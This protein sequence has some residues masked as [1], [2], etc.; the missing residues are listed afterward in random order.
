[1]PAQQ[2]PDGKYAGTGDFP[3]W[4]MKYFTFQFKN[5]QYERT[6]YY[7][8]KN[9]FEALEAND[10]SLTVLDVENRAMDDD[11]M[12][13]LMQSLKENTV[14]TELKLGRNLS[15]HNEQGDRFG[16]ALAPILAKSKIITKVDLHNNDMHEKAIAAIAEALKYNKSITELNLQDNFARKQAKD[17][18]DALKVNTTLTSLNMNVNQKASESTLRAGDGRQSDAAQ[19][20]NHAG[21]P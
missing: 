5:K 3:E 2:T 10:P 11:Q 19:L 20:Y 18:G 8:N 16:L 7:P 6:G 12:Y 15:H 13:E 14:V 17:L 4:T 21:G 1:M 9:L